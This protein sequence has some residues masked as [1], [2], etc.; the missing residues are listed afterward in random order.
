MKKN[1][2]PYPKRKKT[3]SLDKDVFVLT[4]EQYQ[5]L[6]KEEPLHLS[7]DGKSYTREEARQIIMGERGF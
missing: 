5:W 7:G 4:D 6:L 1:H 3:T 2:L